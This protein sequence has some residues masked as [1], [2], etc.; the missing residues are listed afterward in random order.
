MTTDQ[1]VRRSLGED[2]PQPEKLARCG[3]G[4]CTL[5][6]EP[7]IV[8][9]RIL[10]TSVALFIGMLF[11]TAFLEEMSVWNEIKFQAGEAWGVG[12]MIWPLE[13][14]SDSA[15]WLFK[16]YN[17]S[18]ATVYLC[19]PLLAVLASPAVGSGRRRSWLLAPSLLLWATGL[20]PSVSYAAF[21]LWGLGPGIR[22]TLAWIAVALHLSLGVVTL[23]QGLRN[24]SGPGFVF[25]LG[26]YAVL[27]ILTAF[28]CLFATQLLQKNLTGGAGIV[29]M[30][31]LGITIAFTALWFSWWRACSSETSNTQKLKSAESAKASR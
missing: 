28:V 13:E 26:S 25:W 14:G 15:L 17:C 6:T 23:I 7:G 30:L 9:R 11:L 18:F 19:T 5:S 24:R 2:G 3:G 21:H 22:T 27:A 31:A 16:V 10:R 20:I 4:I 1:P 12:R 8:Q 29:A